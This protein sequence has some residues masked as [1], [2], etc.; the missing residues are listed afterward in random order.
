[1]PR[2]S[3]KSSMT[4][5]A[6]TTSSLSSLNRS[7]TS[8]SSPN[9]LPN[10]ALTYPKRFLSPEA[11]R[12]TA[13]AISRALLLYRKQTGRQASKRLVKAVSAFYL[14]LNSQTRALTYLDLTD[15]TLCFPQGL[16]ARLLSRLDEF[17]VSTQERQT[18]LSVI[19]WTTRKSSVVNGSS[20]EKPT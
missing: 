13:E 3:R 2:S 16:R 15:F 17:S 20:E 18:L 9:Y 11:L 19:T 10:A 1:M 5:T 7:I 4:T 14:E 12:E 8:P 6:V